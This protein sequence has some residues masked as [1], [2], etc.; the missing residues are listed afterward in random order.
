MPIWIPHH[1][2]AVS[3]EVAEHIDPELEDKFLDWITQGDRTLLT[4]AP[5]GQGGEH[6]VNEQPKEYWI[7]RMSDRG[8]VYDGILTRKWQAAARKHT[9]N[10]YW[11]VKNAMYF[12]RRISGI[13]T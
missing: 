2:L 11:V 5:P 12:E 13:R 4:A 9:S 1:A 7:E 8:F 3:I 6:H 10:C